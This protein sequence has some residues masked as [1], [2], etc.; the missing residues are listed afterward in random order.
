MSRLALVL[1]L[2][3][4]S[5]WAEDLS[6]YLGLSSTVEAERHA[7]V[8][9]RLGVNWRGYQ[10]F[11]LVSDSMPADV[12]QYYCQVAPFVG[13]RV[14]YRGIGA[15]FES[16]LDWYKE[17]NDD[18]LEGVGGVRASVVLDAR[19]FEDFDISAVP[20]VVAVVGS[21]RPSGKLGGYAFIGSE[22]VGSILERLEGLG[23]DSKKRLDYYSRLSSLDAANRDDWARQLFLKD[24]V[25]DGGDYD[26]SIFKF[27][28]R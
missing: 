6:E 14:V 15:D 19:L 11:F 1:F 27:I 17:R 26:T 2:F 22:R 20:A 10:L 16:V 23:L 18:C 5:V 24:D 7:Q 28:D 21:M 8:L 13:A 25:N 12:I 4:Q 3:V 9:D